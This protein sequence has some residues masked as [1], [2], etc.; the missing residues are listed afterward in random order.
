MTI[1]AHE[2]EE[3]G[4]LF[5]RT[6]SDYDLCVY[7]AL[8]GGRLPDDKAVP[9]YS[10][11]D[12]LI[13]DAIQATFG[14]LGLSLTNYEE[15][16][17]S[18]PY[19]IVRRDGRKLFWPIREQTRALCLCDAATKLAALLSVKRPVPDLQ[20]GFYWFEPSPGVYFYP[21]R[22]SLYGE[23]EILG[24]PF[25]FAS[26]EPFPVFVSGSGSRATVTGIGSPLDWPSND[27]TID[28]PIDR[29]PGVFGPRIEPPKDWRPDHHPERL[30]EYPDLL[31]DEDEDEDEDQASST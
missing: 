24:Y 17:G 20:M 25:A 15:A 12:A 9:P 8:H 5:H 22:F 14:P 29:L 10:T 1:W 27:G 26:S 6:L 18:Q 30:L 7:L 23:K 28:V 31:E 3:T 13:R 2:S 4:R 11:D 21:E 16:H 19:L